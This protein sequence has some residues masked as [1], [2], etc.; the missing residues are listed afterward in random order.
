MLHNLTDPYLPAPRQQYVLKQRSV[1]PKAAIVSI[2]SMEYSI[3]HKL[4][5]IGFSLYIKGH[6]NSGRKSNRTS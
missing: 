3:S 5:V 4:P 1:S 6:N 2:P